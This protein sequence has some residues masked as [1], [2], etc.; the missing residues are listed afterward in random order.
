MRKI[1]LEKR[2]TDECDTIGTIDTSDTI[3][4]IAAIDNIDTFD[5]LNDI[6]L[7]LHRELESFNNFTSEFFTDDLNTTNMEQP[8]ITFSE[9]RASVIRSCQDEL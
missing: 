1:Y 8:N 5:E 6:D 2:S 3:D 7:F 9:E 4:T